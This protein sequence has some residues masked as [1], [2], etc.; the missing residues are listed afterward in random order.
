MNTFMRV[1]ETL[2]HWFAKHGIDKDNITVTFTVSD[3]REKHHIETAILHDIDRFQ[4]KTTTPFE[5]P[6]R[7][8]T[9]FG[10]K[11]EIKP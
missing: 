11:F 4:F 3:F 10:I 9:V 5:R 8:L 6:L 7:K 2:D 1:A